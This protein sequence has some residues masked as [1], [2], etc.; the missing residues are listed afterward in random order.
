M[1]RVVGAGLSHPA[2]GDERASTQKNLSALDHPRGELLACVLRRGPRRV[3]TAE[4]RPAVTAAV[5]ASVTASVGASR[6][7]R[8]PTS[9]ALPAY[10]PWQTRAY[11]ARTA[12]PPWHGEGAVLRS[13]VRPAVRPAVTAAATTSVGD[14]GVRVDEAV[15][16]ARVTHLFS[17]H[18]EV[19]V[20]G[21]DVEVLK[22]AHVLW[23]KVLVGPP[24]VLLPHALVVV[25]PAHQLGDVE[26]NRLGQVPLDAHGVARGAEVLAPRGVLAGRAHPLDGA[27]VLVRGDVHIEPGGALEEDD[28]E[29]VLPQEGAEPFGGVARRPLH[30]LGAAE[31][32]AVEPSRRATRWHVGEVP[33][34][35]PRDVPVG[36]HAVASH[37]THNLRPSVHVRV[38]LEHRLE[39]RCARARERDDDEARGGPAHALRPRAALRKV[40]HRRDGG[41]GEGLPPRRRGECVEARLRQLQEEQLSCVAPENL[42]HRAV[43][44]RLHALGGPLL[45][46]A[47]RH[48]QRAVP[49]HVSRVAAQR[50]GERHH[51]RH[52]AQRCHEV[53]LC[54]HEA[55]PTARVR[56]HVV[57]LLEGVD[58]IGLLPRVVGAGAEGHVHEGAYLDVLWIVARRRAVDHHRRR[59]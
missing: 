14:N 34:R 7:S 19:D 26:R 44:E 49:L 17:G 38:L 13:A 46:E 12:C 41:D 35:P 1:V 57:Q 25:E 32:R 40:D 39:P 36:V 15:A 22:D 51:A 9:G 52:D 31:R 6:P 45:V 3:V 55:E 47:L 8:P 10:G 5:T 27:L 23:A 50:D 18:R 21:V 33:E 54:A 59:A 48:L 20:E 2:E 28:L 43:V 37:L 29:A 53:G 56:D 42:A 4:A 58:H 16:R 24:P 30:S 11:C